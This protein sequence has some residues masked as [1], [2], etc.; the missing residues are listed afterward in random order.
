MKKKGQRKK[1][2]MN[3]VKFKNKIKINKINKKK[4]ERM[5]TDTSM[6]RYI[7]NTVLSGFLRE[8]LDMNVLDF[9]FLY[10]AAE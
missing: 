5:L 3:Y 8:C 10:L 9:N 7:D 2:R 1:E 6:N 4:K